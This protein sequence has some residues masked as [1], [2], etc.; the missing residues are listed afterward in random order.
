[1]IT[2]DLPNIECAPF[3]TRKYTV[4]IVSSPKNHPNPASLPGTHYIQEV[5]IKPD[6]KTLRVPAMF[7]WDDI[8]LIFNATCHT[9]V[10]RYV[11]WAYTGAGGDDLPVISN[12]FSF[13]ISWN[14]DNF[15]MWWGV[16]VVP[17]LYPRIHIPQSRDQ[18]LL[19]RLQLMKHHS[20]YLSA[21]INDFIPAL[22][23]TISSKR[24]ALTNRNRANK[25]T[26]TL[27]SMIR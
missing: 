19:C 26:P 9:D 4:E 10:T 14:D 7:Y 5:E 23:E 15:I 18:H 13:H 8:A 1:M 16:S 12:R 11:G 24:V 22:L 20:P 3:R 17:Y 2:F 21:L 6:Q 25:C 27:E